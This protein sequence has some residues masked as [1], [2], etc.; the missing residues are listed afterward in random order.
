MVKNRAL[1]FR[2]YR[3]REESRYLKLFDGGVTDN[4][5]LHGIITQ[6][7]RYN[8]P[9]APFSP[10]QVVSMKDL[11]FIVVNASAKTGENIHKNVEGPNGV[12][13]LGAVVNTLMA[14]ATTRTRDEFFLAMQAWRDDIIEYRCGLGADRV[15]ELIG[16]QQGWDC[17]DVHFDILDLSFAQVRDQGLRAKLEKIPTAYVLPRTQIDLLVKS[18]GELLRNNPQFSAFLKRVR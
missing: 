10:K 6:R 16:D 8:S 7:E 4:L 13:V 18:A 11:L 15:R 9:I 1:T 14:T 12:H 17:K 2:R 5:G 3:N